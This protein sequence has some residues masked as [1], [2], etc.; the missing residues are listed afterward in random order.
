M[1]ATI[2]EQVRALLAACRL[3][4]TASFKTKN[5]EIK[6]ATAAEVNKMMKE[7]Y[8]LSEKQKP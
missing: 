6:G 8:R 5:L 4:P 2:V 3:V 7:H 1:W